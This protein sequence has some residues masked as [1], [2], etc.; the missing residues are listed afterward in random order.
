MEELH[1]K[2]HRLILI[3]TGAVIVLGYL[4]TLGAY[5]AGRTHLDLGTILLFLLV[6]AFLYIATGLIASRIPSHKATK[7]IIVISMGIMLF[8][9]N[10]F[11]SQ[12]PEAFINLIM[13]IIASVFYS[14]LFFSL[15]ST[16]LVLAIYTLSIVLFPQIIGDSS[17]LLI[18]YTDF[19]L[20]GIMAALA[21]Y[22][23]SHLMGIGLKDKKRL[24]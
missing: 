4:A 21:S 11:V 10:V 13:I 22:Y 9:Y 15:L 3:A 16:L 18:R 8:I 12:S 19:I 14:E 7:Y 24:T 17:Q 6:T 1:L 23:T 2:R 5:F 20:L